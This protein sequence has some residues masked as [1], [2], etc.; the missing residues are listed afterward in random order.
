MKATATSKV[1]KATW[2]RS[3]VTKI[4]FEEEAVWFP[5]RVISKCPATILAIKRTDRVKGRIT[6]LTLSIKTMKGIRRVGVLCGTIWANM[7]FILLN[8][9]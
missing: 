6:F 2:V 7:W 4:K 8:H 3:R 5:K 9:P 1:N